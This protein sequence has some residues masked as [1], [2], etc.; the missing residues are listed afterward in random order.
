[1]DV[2]VIRQYVDSRLKV[3]ETYMEHGL[4]VE[5]R[6]VFQQIS[7]N[8]SK[9]RKRIDGCPVDFIQWFE[10]VQGDIQEKILLLSQETPS[11]Y[12]SAIRGRED[13]QDGA[14][15]NPQSEYLKGI[16]LKDLGFHDDAVECF[17]NALQKGHHPYECPHEFL[18]VCKQKENGL[19]L[20]QE[21]KEALNTYVMSPKECAELWGKLGFL[22]DRSGQKQEAAEFLAH[23]REL[24]SELPKAGDAGTQEK[25]KESGDIPFD[26]IPEDGARTEEDIEI[27]FDVKGGKD[28]NPKEE[29]DAPLEAPDDLKE[30]RLETETAAGA[31]QGT[32]DIEDTELRNE[33]ARVRADLA[34]AQ[35]LVEEYQKRYTAIMSQTNTLQKEN[36]DL[37]K[38]LAAL[39]KKEAKH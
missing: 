31:G 1:M 27:Q 35:E 18:D 26:G 8:L 5:S 15:R 23:A 29:K 13:E 24:M 37:Q 17:R 2:T 30:L 22:Y 20:A 12:S 32:D 11:A 7:V 14:E 16:G 39:E 21:V 10:S 25:D 36:R 9:I 6:D 33:L 4:V 34:R 38:K 28:E 3:A 19:E